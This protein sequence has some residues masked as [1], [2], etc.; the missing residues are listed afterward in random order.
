MRSLKFLGLAT[1]AIVALSTVASLASASPAYLRAEKYST[2]LTGKATGETGKLTTSWGAKLCTSP[3][4]GS[5]I[6]S[7]TATLPTEVA[8][9][10]SCGMKTNG[11]QFTFNT[12]TA[13]Q[14][15]SVKGTFDISCPA[16]KAIEVTIVGS[17][18]AL[19][20][21]Q[22]GL[23][24]SF[25]NNGSGSGQTVIVKAEVLTGL[26]YEMTCEKGKTHTDGIYK[27]TWNL[28]ASTGPIHISGATGAPVQGL[29]FGA[30]PNFAAE[31]YPALITGTQVSQ[32]KFKMPAAGPIQCKTSKLNTELSAAASELVATPEYGT[33]TLAGSYVVTPTVT[34][35][36]LTF[37]LLGSS[38]EGNGG[39]SCSAGNELTYRVLN[40]DGTTRCT[41]TIPSYTP[42]GENYTFK[43]VGSGKSRQVEAIANMSAIKYHITTGCGVAEGTYSDG[44]FTGSTLFTAYE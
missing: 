17:C 6:S 24:A 2:F 23:P 43:N 41:V 34:G 26:K 9:D 22:T 29:Y 35:C 15:I 12:G 32:H 14:Q 33:C 4:L 20:T 5:Y 38:G 40:F 7:Q 19:I 30:G 18:T 31:I 11:C 3:T 13:E 21:S 39:I 16:G 1:L 27:T 42:A 28:S 8:S 25:T 10:S 37:K 36:S 44:T